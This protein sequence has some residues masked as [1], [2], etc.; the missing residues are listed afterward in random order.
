MNKKINLLLLS[1]LLCI[2]TAFAQVSNLILFT[3]QGEQFTVILN[4]IKQNDKPETNVKVTGLN[5]PN[6]KLKVLFVNKSIPD[7]DKT[8]FIEA[9]SENTYSIKKNAQGV[10][11]IRLQST[12]PMAESVPSTPRQS[13]VTYHSTPTVVQQSTTT[14]TTYGEP[15][16]VNINVGIGGVGMNMN[17]TGM[18]A[19]GTSQTTTTTTTTTSSNYD[20]PAQQPRQTV[21]VMPGYNGPVGC[22]W[23]LSRQDFESVKA[24][25]SSKSFDDT[26]LTI[27][28]Q[29]IA[30]NCLLSSQVKEIMMLFSFEDTRLDLAK[31][32]YGYTFDI[33][34]YF[35]INDAFSFESSIDELNTYINGF[36]R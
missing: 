14:T 29:V 9:G 24:S 33:G 16:N 27:A 22:P 20:Q 13:V 8:V 28:K 3:E 19:Y 23:P 31:Y 18:D 5:A 2:S 1:S 30:S 35:K 15:D 7:M 17:V 6:Y 36:Q 10:Y 4:G 34:N 32:A 11:T 26:K 21:Y 25:I 12:V